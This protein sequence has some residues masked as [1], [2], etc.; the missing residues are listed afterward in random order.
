MAFNFDYG[1]GLGV[2][3]RKVL[4]KQTDLIYAQSFTYPY[5]QTFGFD[6]KPNA[7]TAMQFT[8]FESFGAQGVGVF[9]PASN[10]NPAVPNNQ[11]ALLAQPSQGTGGFSFSFQKLF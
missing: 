6:I 9:T 7:T 2:S 3:A 8:V 10:I 1:G 4:G 11:R 5:R